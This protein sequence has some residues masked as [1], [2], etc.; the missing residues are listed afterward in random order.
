VLS[1]V[2]KGSR[3]GHQCLCLT[4]VDTRKTIESRQW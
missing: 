2:G 1:F 3:R 4:E